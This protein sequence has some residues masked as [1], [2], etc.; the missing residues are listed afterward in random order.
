MAFPHR[1]RVHLEQR[2]EET[3]LTDGAKPILLGGP[4]PEGGGRPSW[5]SPEHLLASSVGLCFTSTFRAL[6]ARTQL[7]PRRY[8]ADVETMLDR[9]ADGVQFTSFV[10]RVALEVAPGQIELAARLLDQAKLHCLV[11]KTLKAPVTLASSVSETPVRRSGAR[12]RRSCAELCARDKECRR[13]R[14]RCG[15]PGGGRAPSPGPWS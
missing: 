12:R 14:P 6:A 8:T 1:Y 7:S 10:I 15:G 13:A 9:T 11:V 3:V 4:P 5:W 2:G